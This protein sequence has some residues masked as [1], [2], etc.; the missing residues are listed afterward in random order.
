MI[1]NLSLSR[2]PLARPN[3]SRPPPSSEH[4]PSRW[5]S[6]GRQP[7]VARTS[8]RMSSRTRMRS[9]DPS[10]LIHS[11][12][13]SFPHDD[14]T[15]QNTRHEAPLCLGPQKFY[16]CTRASLL[17]SL[18]LHSLSRSDAH[19]DPQPGAIFETIEKALAAGNRRRQL[20]LV[21]E[22]PKPAP[23][24]PTQHPASRALHIPFESLGPRNPPPASDVDRSDQ[25]GRSI[26]P[27]AFDACA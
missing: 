13:S 4:S 2:D 10:T 27:H 12:L 16:L 23:H 11:V 7:Q 5:T 8:S 18:T 1:A 19:T 24:L 9:S 17:R 6:D 20:S 15:S 22:G 26:E 3:V 14:N 21:V 25:L